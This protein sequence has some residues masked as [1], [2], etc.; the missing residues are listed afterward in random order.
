MVSQIQA[1]NDDTFLVECCYLIA[2]TQPEE[3][4]QG[5]VAD[6]YQDVPKDG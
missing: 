4:D 2:M 3:H 5:I 6:I 1:D